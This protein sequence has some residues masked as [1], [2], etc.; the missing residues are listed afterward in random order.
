MSDKELLQIC[1][2]KDEDTETPINLESLELDFLSELFG[3]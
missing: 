1:I 3:L 2:D